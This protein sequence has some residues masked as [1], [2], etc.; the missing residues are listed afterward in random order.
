MSYISAPLPGAKGLGISVLDVSES[1]SLPRSPKEKSSSTREP[2]SCLHTL[3]RYE[4]DTWAWE[5]FNI[6]LSLAALATVII[7][8]RYYDGKAAP[9]W[10]YS[11]TLNAF[12]SVCMM[13]MGAA[14]TVP[15]SNGTGQLKWLMAR[16]GNVSV[17][18]LDTLDRASRGMWGS[19]CA[20]FTWSGGYVRMMTLRTKANVVQSDRLTWCTHH[21]CCFRRFTVRPASIVDSARTR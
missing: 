4:C 10:P 6:V 14:L 17:V 5:I 2:R 3:Y 20:I 8:L 12:V 19:V 11:L 15:V 16:K 18:A 13:I 21:N 7:A 9:E 1:K